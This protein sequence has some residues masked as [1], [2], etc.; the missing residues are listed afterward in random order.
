MATTVKSDPGPGTVAQ[1]GPKHQP[2][3]GLTGYP[4]QQAN[5]RVADNSEVEVTHLEGR[6]AFCSR[7]MREVE[8]F[9]SIERKAV[10]EGFPSCGAEGSFQ[11]REISRSVRSTHSTTRFSA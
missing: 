2:P 10:E 7:L 9:A 5:F 3:W 4:R 6:E 1:Y 8:K 11:L